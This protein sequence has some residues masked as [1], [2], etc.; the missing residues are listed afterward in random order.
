MKNCNSKNEELFKDIWI[1]SF[2][3]TV[4][5]EMLDFVSAICVLC[6]RENETM[7]YFYIRRGSN[8]DIHMV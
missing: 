6:E 2:Y 8:P 3:G 4:A 7:D 5:M 1:F